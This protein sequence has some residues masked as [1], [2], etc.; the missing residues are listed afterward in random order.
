MAVHTVPS[1][2]PGSGRRVYPGF[3]QISGFIGMDPRR[4]VKAFGGLFRDLHNDDAIAAERTMA[5]YGE[6]FAVIDI[7]AEFYLE[8]AQRIFIANDLPQGSFTFRGR[9]IDPSV[10]RSALFTI[11][12]RLDEM[13]CPGQ[14]QAAHTLC[15]SIPEA[16]RRHLLQEGVGHTASSRV[17][18]STVRS[19]R[20]SASSSS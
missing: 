4:H 14:T 13:C 6:Y 18:C 3:L 5:F 17:R 9:R 2:F 1:K 10:L 19:T 7:A 11:E 15:S 20:R 12:G 8:T 16:R